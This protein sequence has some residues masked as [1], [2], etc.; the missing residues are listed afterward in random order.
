MLKRISITWILL[1]I[2]FTLSGC[3]VFNAAVQN[4]IEQTQTVSIKTETASKENN[5][6]SFTSNN[7]SPPTTKPS[8]TR[9]SKPTEKPF[10]R[11]S[12]VTKNMKGQTIEVCGKVTYYGEEIC[13]ECVYGYYAYLILDDNFYIISYDWT[14][15]T[16]WVGS[17]FI[18][19][20][21][22]ETMGSKPIF[23]YGGKEG[24]DGSECEVMPNGTLTCDVGE[25]F[26]F[27]NDCY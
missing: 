17:Y 11:A 4:A 7:Q 1:S 14:F 5:T 27:V 6:N 9:T 20:D 19:K 26:K 21:K 12:E 16:G 15:D 8:P 13:P 23:V 3:D 2:I 10:I 22:V 25:Y 18:A 24:W